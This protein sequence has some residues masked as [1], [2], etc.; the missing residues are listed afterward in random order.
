M[1]DLTKLIKDLRNKTG[2]G[3]LD[4]KNA[5]IDNNNDIEKAVEQLRKKGLAK[6]AKKISREATEGAI[7]IFSNDNQVVILK[8]NSETDFA[9]KSETFLNYL[10]YLGEAALSLNN[11][12]LTKDEF[13]KS[14]YKD[15]NIKDSINAMIAKIGENLIL[16][17]LISFSNDNYFNYYIHNSYKANIGKIISYIRYNASEKNNVDNFSKNLC[18][19]IAAMKPESLDIED[20]D[21]NIVE[22]EKIIQKDLIQSSGKPSEIIDKI[23]D[24][25]MKKF[26]S[27]I[28]LLNQTYILDQ[29]KS[30][31]NIIEDFSKETEFKILSFDLISLN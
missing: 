30:V 25:K 22:K 27:E 6:A 16:N 23:L 15:T 1:S 28:T 31:K 29:E 17:D 13:L 19:H 12:N 24:G 7:G 26:Y 11:I 4:C 9:A 5:L 21:S 10:D 3:F 8:M 18:M 14:N 2:A 20:L